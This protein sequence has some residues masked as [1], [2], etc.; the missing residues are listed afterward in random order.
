MCGITL[1]ELLV[2]FVAFVVGADVVCAGAL[3]DF[4]DDFDDG[5][6]PDAADDL[7]NDEQREEVVADAGVPANGSVAVVVRG[8]KVAPDGEAAMRGEGGG[9]GGGDEVGGG[10]RGVGEVAAGCHVD[11]GVGVDGPADHHVEDVAG[12]EPGDDEDAKGDVAGGGVAHVF[13]E[14]GSL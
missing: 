14:F 3:E 6:E 11:R 13:E 2:F 5:G 9:V 7:E 1:F 12:E 10:G 4:V 8:E